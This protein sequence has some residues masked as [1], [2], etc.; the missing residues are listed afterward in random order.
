MVLGRQQPWATR[1]RL[2]AQRQRD[3]GPHRR[4]R[5]LDRYQL[6][7]VPHVRDRERRDVV[8]LGLELLRSA[9]RRRHHGEST[10]VQIGAGG[11]RTG[12]RIRGSQHTCAIR[13]GQLWCWGYNSS[14]QVGDGTTTERPHPLVSVP[15]PTGATSPSAAASTGA[16]S[17]PA[18]SSGA[19]ATTSTARSAT[20]V[21]T[22][23][24]AP[25][26]I[27]GDAGAWTAVALG[28]FHACG[29]HCRAALLLG[30]QH[31]R[32]ARRRDDLHAVRAL[33]IGTDTNWGKPRGQRSCS[34]A[35]PR[36]A[37][38]CGA[39]ETTRSVSSATRRPPATARP[40][41]FGTVGNWSSIDAGL[42]TPRASSA[43]RNRH[44]FGPES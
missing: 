38:S 36:P 33:Q 44:Q 34:R 2:H 4:E 21:N 10:P 20:G 3:P 11:S 29:V 15:T 25:V 22:N 12:L 24:T 26:R 41:R 16:A 40:A 1:H 13:A 14:G 35:A 5:R 19:G 18:G 23:R 8:V 17:R 9:R 27:G 6:R 39:G 28:G 37:A 42:T 43:R 7:H 32:A 30:A 31:E